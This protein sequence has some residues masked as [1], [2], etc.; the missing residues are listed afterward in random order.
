MELAAHYE[1]DLDNDRQRA[2]LVRTTPSLQQRQHERLAA[3]ESI[4]M[5]LIAE[6]LGVNPVDDLRPALIA[7]CA[8]AAIRVAA[9]Q[10]LL[11]DA[12][13]PLMPIVEQALSILTKAFDDVR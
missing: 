5:P 3:F 8:V 1:H 13:R 12:S 7:A 9:S 4:I 6:R 10:W 2:A 11:G